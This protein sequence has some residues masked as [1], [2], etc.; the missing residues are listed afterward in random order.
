MAHARRKFFAA[1]HEKTKSAGSREALGRIAGLYRIEDEIRGRPPDQRLSVRANYTAPLMADLRTWLEATLTR[2]SGR[3]DLAAAIRY[4]LARWEA[5]TLILRDG[6]AGTCGPPYRRGERDHG[7]P[8]REEKVRP[9]DL[10]DD[11]GGVPA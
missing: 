1:E 8:W 11:A 5:L 10:D 4:T 3:S 6:R 7:G 2:I 9:A